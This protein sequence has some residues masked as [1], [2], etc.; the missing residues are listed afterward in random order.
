MRLFITW[1]SKIIKISIITQRNNMKDCKNCWAVNLCNMCYQHWS[2][3]ESM[4]AEQAIKKCDGIKLN[5]E[6]G[7]SRFCSIMEDDNDF[8]SYNFL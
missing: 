6:K 8:F 4:Q 5:L 3:G 7:L 2:D 1:M